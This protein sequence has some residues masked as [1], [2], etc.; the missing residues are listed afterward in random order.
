MNYARL[1]LAAVVAWVVDSVYGYL[2]FGLAMSDEYAK[3][4]GVF[5]SFDAVSGML[6]LM[7]G[8]SLVGM[9]AVAYI[10]AKGHE[11]RPGLQEGLRFGIVFAL[12]GLFTLSIPNYVIYNYGRRMAAM[13]A[14]AA[15][16]EMILIGVILGMV[17]KPA[18]T[19][20]REAR[21]VGV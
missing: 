15:F 3:Y 17:Y 9:L 6:P 8:A 4:P 2:V 7:F 1:A 19:A 18:S 20:S 16:V 11:G 12:F 5:R 21:A 13:G 10:F 14:V